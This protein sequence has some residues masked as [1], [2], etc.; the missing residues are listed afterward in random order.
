[1][2]DKM[3][4]VDRANFNTIDLAWEAHR[5]RN[6]IAHEGDAHHMS[7]REVRRVIALFERVL[8][9]FHYIQ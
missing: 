1:M 6:K 5:I 8:K 4:G 3:R 2:A 7:A 9:E